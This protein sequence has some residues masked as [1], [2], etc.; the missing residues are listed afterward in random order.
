LEWL[1]PTKES[2]LIAASI[3]WKTVKGVTRPDTFE[4][5]TLLKTKHCCNFL[6]EV[7]YIER[8]QMM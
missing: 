6:T 8:L 3:T 2:M 5:N 1:L 4:A 7:Y